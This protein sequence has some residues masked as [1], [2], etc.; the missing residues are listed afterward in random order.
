MLR[1]LFSQATHDYSNPLLGTPHL[2]AK[3]LS[4]LSMFSSFYFSD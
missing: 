4:L 2:L 3:Y 1:S